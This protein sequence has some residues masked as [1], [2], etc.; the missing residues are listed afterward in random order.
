[1]IERDRRPKHA[2]VEIIATLGRHVQSQGE[3]LGYTQKLE[4]F[5][6][7]LINDTVRVLDVIIL[8]CGLVPLTTCIRF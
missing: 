1:M 5:G 8:L 4:S 3:E 6:L 7:K 2:D